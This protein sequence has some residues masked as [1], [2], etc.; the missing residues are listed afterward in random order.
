MANIQYSKIFGGSLPKHVFPLCYQSSSTVQAKGG[1]TGRRVERINGLHLLVWCGCF[2][3]EV[4]NSSQKKGKKGPSAACPVISFSSH[5]IVCHVVV[6]VFEDVDLHDIS[7]LVQKLNAVLT[8]MTQVQ[9]GSVGQV[10]FRERIDGLNG[11][12]IADA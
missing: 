3:A 12:M 1:F 7:G 2:K 5:L 9:L 4:L 6:G 8:Q 11:R 10:A